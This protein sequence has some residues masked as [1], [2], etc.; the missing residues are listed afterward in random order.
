M[1]NKL[2]EVED[3]R[4]IANAIRANAP[5]IVGR[6]DFSLSEMPSGIDDVYMEGYENGLDKGYDDGYIDG[7]DDGYEVGFEAGSAGGVVNPT[8]VWEIVD[9]P[10]LTNLP[11][12]VASSLIANFN[13]AGIDYVGI[14]KSTNKLTK[15]ST[16]NY[17]KSDNSSTVVY[18]EGSGWSNEAY[19]TVTFPEEITVEALLSWLDAEGN[20]ILIGNGEV[21][22]SEIEE[23]LVSGDESYDDEGKQFYSVYKWLYVYNSSLSSAPVTITVM[24]NHPTLWIHAYIRVFDTAGNAYHFTLPIE[25]DQGENS[26]EVHFPVSHFEVEGIRWS[27]R[28]I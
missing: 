12:T 10:D 2:Y 22:E 6:R 23:M 5:N 25:Y 15:K 9:T 3:V 27:R 19:R 13:S 28:G 20:A 4:R 11:T 17:L 8:T 24:N 18:T 7:Y 21:N 16:L 26:I 14:Y 1:A